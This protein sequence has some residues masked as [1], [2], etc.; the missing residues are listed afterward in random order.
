MTIYFDK[1]ID[2]KNYK[3]AIVYVKNEKIQYVQLEGGQLEVNTD[4]DTIT[5]KTSRELA[6]FNS[7]DVLAIKFV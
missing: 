7:D 4:D 1:S 3:G 2:L 5:V 6:L